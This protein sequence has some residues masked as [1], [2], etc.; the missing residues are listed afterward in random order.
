MIER[1]PEDYCETKNVQ[2]VVLP[3]VAQKDKLINIFLK[4]AR[5]SFNQA[6]SDYHKDYE[7]MQKEIDSFSTSC[8][9]CPYNS[10]SLALS[11]QAFLKRKASNY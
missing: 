5:K 4:E 11:A 8:P 1:K 3:L 7:T 2:C 10:K 9:D 6:S